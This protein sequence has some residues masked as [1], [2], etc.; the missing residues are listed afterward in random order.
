MCVVEN[1]DQRTTRVFRRTLDPIKR[2]Q[3]VVFA[4]GYSRLIA[5]YIVHLSIYLP[6][7]ARDRKRTGT[8]DLRSDAPT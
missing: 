5:H 1:M 2:V 4:A 7:P 8:L 6:N 3:Y